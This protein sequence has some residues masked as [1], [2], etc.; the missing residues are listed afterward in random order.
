MNQIPISP[1]LQNAQRRNEDPEVGIQSE[2]CDR[3]PTLFERAQSLMNKEYDR[4]VEFLRDH[5]SNKIVERA[6]ER[7]AWIDLKRVVGS[8]FR[9]EIQ[10]EVV[11]RIL[12]WLKE[13]GFPDVKTVEKELMED[14][15]KPA[16]RRSF[17]VHNTPYRN[18]SNETL[19][20]EW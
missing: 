7:K 19:L 13:E 16:S 10:P 6:T 12:A 2:K 5:I 3:S 1:R 11:K 14:L 20:L 17:N 8:Q 9:V 15:A 4:Q 18:Y